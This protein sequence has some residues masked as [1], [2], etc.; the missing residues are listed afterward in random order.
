MSKQDPYCSLMIG[1][2]KRRTA[3]IKK[4][5]QHP[6]WDEQVKF[7]IYEDMADQLARTK[8]EQ[9]EDSLG[10]SASSKREKRKM[11]EKGAKTM[12]VK[13]Y[14]DAPREPE[15][16]GEAVFDLAKALNSGEDEG[17]YSVH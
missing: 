14:A 9:T 13:C 10:A 7:D 11:V 6:E 15:L 16:I 2:D 3:A 8:D 1:T 5:G 17:Q 12:T 4:G